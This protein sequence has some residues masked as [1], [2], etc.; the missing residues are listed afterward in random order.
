VSKKTGDDVSFAFGQPLIRIAEVVRSLPQI[1]LVAGKPKVSKHQLVFGQQGV[2]IRFQ[3]SVM[4][5][6][7]GQRVANVD[8]VVAPFEGKLLSCRGGAQHREEDKQ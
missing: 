5:H 2:D 6:A 4:L 3:P 8:N 7:I 1:D